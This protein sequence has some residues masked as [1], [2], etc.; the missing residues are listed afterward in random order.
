MFLLN[1]DIKAAR[2]IQL[3]TLMKKHTHTHTHRHT[4]MHTHLWPPSVK[5]KFFTFL[6]RRLPKTKPPWLMSEVNAP[7]HRPCSAT[8]LLMDSQAVPSCCPSSAPHAWPTLAIPW[9]CAIPPSCC[10]LSR[11]QINQISKQTFCK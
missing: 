3:K 1:D 9:P 11:T 10:I 2:T 4:H 6:G 8:S 5:T 7:Q